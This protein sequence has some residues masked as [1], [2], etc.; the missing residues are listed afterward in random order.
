MKIK[1]IVDKRRNLWYN[2]YEDKVIDGLSTGGVSQL[3]F[4]K[5]EFSSKFVKDFARYIADKYED[6]DVFIPESTLS[7]IIY[8]KNQNSIW[9][10]SLKIK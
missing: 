7:I 6:I 4:D 8:L 3:H 9:F 5:T 10:D 2:K 1:E